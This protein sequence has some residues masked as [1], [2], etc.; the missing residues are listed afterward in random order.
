MSTLVREDALFSW[1]EGLHGAHWGSVLDAGSGD[2][3]LRWL[4]S[5]GPGSLTGVTAESWR[6]EGLRQVAPSARVLLGEWSDPALLAGERFDVVVADYVIGSIDGHAPYF[7][8]EFL[9]RLRPHVADRLYLVGLEPQPRDGSVLDEVCRVRDAAIL[10]AGH[11][12]Y[13]EYPR[14]VVLAWL[15]R[16]GFKVIDSRS[17]PNRLGARFVNGQLDVAARK[18]PA[19]QDRGV[20]SAMEAHIVELRARALAAVPQV[21]GVDWVIAA[22]RG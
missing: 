6:M 21:W 5:L 9:Q 12:C 18:L 3:S 2:H 11:R 14:D 7:Q 17:F 8:Y 1:F 15:G 10:L 20:A 19:F 16:A 13:R 4:Q 22:E